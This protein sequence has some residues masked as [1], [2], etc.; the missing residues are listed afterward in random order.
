[1]IF[2]CNDQWLDVGAS[3]EKEWDEFGRWAGV[4]DIG[5]GRFAVRGRGTNREG[6]FGW[7]HGT[8]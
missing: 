6:A 3:A 5:R 7:L 1:M 4:H 8:G 2:E